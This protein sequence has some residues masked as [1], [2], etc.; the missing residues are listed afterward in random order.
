MSLLTDII[1][2]ILTVVSTVGGTVIAVVIYIT[3]Q[4]AKHDK[5]EAVM[6][7]QLK[8]ITEKI[9]KIM[10]N[11]LPH[12]D[13]KINTLCDKVNDIDKTLFAHIQNDK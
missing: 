12:I 6:D 8:N 11:H 10:T 4:N 9:D 3:K 2:P 13:Q 5:R 1:I 7:V